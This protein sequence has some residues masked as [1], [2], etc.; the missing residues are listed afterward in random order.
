[1]KKFS[2]E[3]AG[4]KTVHEALENITKQVKDKVATNCEEMCTLGYW[5]KQQRDESM[6]MV[7]GSEPV[8][9]MSGTGLC[10][11]C[12]TGETNPSDDYE[13]EFPEGEPS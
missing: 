2:R 8:W 4:Y 1:M 7:C 13:L 5:L 3:F 6:C 10:F 12:C 11:T 9:R